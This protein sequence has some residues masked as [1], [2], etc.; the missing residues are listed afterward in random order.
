MNEY[1]ALTAVPVDGRISIELSDLGKL[2]VCMIARRFIKDIH[3][4]REC[5]V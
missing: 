1:M 3:V 4:S 2:Q 5:T